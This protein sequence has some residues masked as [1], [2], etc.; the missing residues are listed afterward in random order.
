MKRF[1]RKQGFTLIEMIV[2]LVILAIL[3]AIT[4]PIV[5]RYIDDAHDA[6]Y[7]ARG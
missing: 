4:I 3:L 2:V 5:T 6:T 1:V 7:L